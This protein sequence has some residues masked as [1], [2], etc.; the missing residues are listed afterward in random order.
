MSYIM[1]KKGNTSSSLIHICF[2]S[3]LHT[4]QVIQNLTFLEQIKDQLGF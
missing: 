2:E 4:H 3:K 1:R